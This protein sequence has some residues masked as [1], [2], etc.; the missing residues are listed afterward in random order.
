MIENVESRICTTQDR[1]AIML[2]RLRKTGQINTTPVR[3]F[4]DSIQHA[5]QREVCE[6]VGCL[7]SLT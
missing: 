5:D 3:H 4:V 6:V 2:K 7:K 1:A